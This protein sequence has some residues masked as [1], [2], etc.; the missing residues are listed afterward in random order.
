MA[1]GIPQYITGCVSGTGAEIIVQG[2]KCPFAPKLVRLYNVGDPGGV[3]G[4][5][6]LVWMDDMANDSGY[7]TVD[8][9]V[10]ATDKSLITTNGISVEGLVGFG[11]GADADINAGGER[12]RYEAWG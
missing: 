10:G 6:E 4:G 1:S 3:G 8:S 12:I 7:K 11:I 9:G 2:G 5:A